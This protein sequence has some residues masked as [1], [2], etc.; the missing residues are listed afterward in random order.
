MIDVENCPILTEDLQSILTEVR[1]TIDW[2]SF[3][4]E[5]IVIEAAS[6]DGNVSIYSNE[7]IEPTEEISF[8]AR[9]ENISIRQ[10]VF[11]R[12]IRF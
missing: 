10:K 2:N 8:T 6:A 12:A 9:G 11:F 5:K 7:I 3:W 4:S 1:E